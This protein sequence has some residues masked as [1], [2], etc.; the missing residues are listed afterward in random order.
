M[1]ENQARIGFVGGGN[2]AQAIIKGLLNA[3]HAP[4]KIMVADPSP[5]QRETLQQL[6]P[7]ISVS[8][9][10][11]ELAADS[12]VLI[13][14]VK[15]QILP[16]IAMHLADV[17]RAS[18][19][20]IISVAAGITL[21][22]LHGW[23]GNS[24]SIVRVMPNTPALIGAGMSGLYADASMQQGLREMAAYV[25]DATGDTLWVE[26]E[27]LIDAITA[28]SGSGPA[29]FFLVM[30]IMQ[31]IAEE[32]GFSADDAAL[33]VTR[34]AAG[35]GLLA[36]G[37]DET[38]AVLRARV[39][40]PGGTTAAA[41]A[42]LEQGGIRDIFRTALFAARDRSFELGTPIDDDK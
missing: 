14:A 13:L 27:D 31:E 36:A 34:T 33:L 28:V 12:N 19:Q 39:T 37:S 3:G 41:L 24:A 10:S 16:G 8:A 21:Q 23:L 1:Q 7:D 29:Y 32:L 20:L 26:D 4:D 40:S 9:D 35:A 17:P 30:E 18:G 25:M 22:S 11:D 42:A 5:E 15:P 2:M 6:S 38:A